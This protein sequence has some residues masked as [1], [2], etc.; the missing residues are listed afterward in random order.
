MRT[1]MIHAVHESVPLC[2]QVDNTPWAAAEVLKIDKHPWFR[3]GQKHATEARL[4]YDRRAVHVQ[5][6]CCD[7]HIFSMVTELNGPVCRDSCVEFFATVDPQFGPHYFNLEV[8]CCGTFLMQFGPDSSHRAPITPEQAERVAIAASHPGP[9]KDESDDD[10]GWWVAAS[11][12]FDL[13]SEMSSRRVGP[14]A[15]TEWRGNF[16][17][18]GGRTNAQYACWNEVDGPRPNF[19]RPECFG[20]LRF[21]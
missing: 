2:G 7:S 13:L 4:L 3:G 14:T 6:L 1:Y 18:C 11:I 21:A 9:T 17:R 12:P 20:L 16:Y 15:G 10:D 19:H 5:F 8:N